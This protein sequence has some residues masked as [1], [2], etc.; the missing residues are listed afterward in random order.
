MLA[1]IAACGHSA[2]PPTSPLPPLGSDAAKPPAP[3]YPPV[4]AAHLEQQ[5]TPYI[6]SIGAKL[7]EARR[8]EGFVLVAQGGK[9][10][11]QHAFGFADRD[12]R[13]VADADTNFRVGSIT[14]QF[15]SAAIMV[16]QQDGKLSV[17]DPIGKYLPDYPEVGRAITLD[18]LLTHTSGIP[19]Y[20]E[21]PDFAERVATA[22][23][24]AQLLAYFDD[25]PLEF[26]PGAQHHYS[27]SNYIVLGAIIEKV[28]GTSYADFVT[29]RLFE[30][31]GLTRTVVGD[32]DGMTNRAVGYTVDPDDHLAPASPIDMSVPYAAGAVRSTAMDLVRWAHALDG[33][34]ILT[35]ASK[36]RMYTPAKDNYAFGWIVEEA[37]GHRVLW[38][39]GQVNGFRATFL[40][41]PDRDL[42]VVVWGNNDQFNPDPLA[43]A[44]TGIAMGNDVA[45]VVEPD[46]V[47]LDEAAAARIVGHYKLT[48]DSLAAAQQGGVE[49]DLIATLTSLDVVR[50]GAHLTFKLNGQRPFD[51]DAL[52]PTKFVM[53]EAKIEIVVT[54]PGTGNATALTITQGP[55]A[56]T[57]ARD[58]PK[59]PA[60]PKRRPGPSRGR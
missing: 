38:H 1:A 43:Q 10:I 2:P 53:L 42:V 33:D 25:K 56:L 58:E 46:L 22:Q 57:Y 37:D 4:D 35:A 7:G 45:P 59:A 3:T 16:L 18:Q 26:T 14:K 29:K 31:A 55:L 19:E 21:A 34:A 5:L 60:P 36:Q 47:P 52:G 15:T 11:Y 13:T 51:V 44:A 41:I 48:D 24:P 17:D 8:L 49:A 54:L 32:A 40:R 39:N 6:S 9:P 30:P 20:S 23:T 50:T 28:S 27:N 12:K